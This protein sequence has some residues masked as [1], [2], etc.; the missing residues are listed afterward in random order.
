MH[1]IAEG[2][3]NKFV[4]VKTSKRR[5]TS[6]NLW[7]KRQL[8]DPYVAKAKIEGYRSRSSYKLL[9]IHKKFNLFKRNMRIIDLG[10]APGGWSQVAA[11]IIRSD[12]INNQNK[13]IG[14]DLLDIEDIPGVTFIKGD[15]LDFDNINIIKNLLGQNKVDLVM[16]DMAANSTGH[17]ATDHIRI[18]NLCEH[19]LDF[20][21]TIL[22]A[23]GNFIVKIFRGGAENELLTK[24]KSNFHFVKHFKPNASRKE[25]T[26]LYL[27]AMKRK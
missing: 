7:L 14:I 4:K 3:R 22:K 19:A 1:S 26:E 9:E 25:S 20:A 5:K 15:F 16:S 12:L 17:A 8:N 11:S 2:Y 21:L 23:D 6:S 18:M 27:V 24:V 10:C 13:I